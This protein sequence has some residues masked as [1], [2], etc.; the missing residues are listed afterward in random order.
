MVPGYVEAG[1]LAGAPPEMLAGSEPP[2]YT[3]VVLLICV[4]SAEGLLRARH[5]GSPLEQLHSYQ[6]REDKQASIV[7]CHN[8]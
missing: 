6:S 3:K 5:S 7:K 4:A 2:V 8:Q 1:G